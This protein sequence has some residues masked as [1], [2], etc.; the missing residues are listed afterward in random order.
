MAQITSDKPKTIATPQPEAILDFT[1]KKSCMGHENTM[2]KVML[3]AVS[4]QAFGFSR[5]MVYQLLNRQDL[6]VVVI[7]KRRFMHREL[8]LKWLEEQATAFKEGA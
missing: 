8:F 2:E 7:G 3:D 6:P 1:E 5:A 4:L